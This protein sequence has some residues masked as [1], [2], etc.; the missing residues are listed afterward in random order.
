MYPELVRGRALSV[1]A[2]VA[3]NASV[4]ASCAPHPAAAPRAS[5]PCGDEQVRIEHFCIDR[6]EDYV[7]EVDDQGREKPH[8]PYD[9]IGNK[10][11]RARVAKGVVPQAYISQVQAR[12]AC[13]EAGKRLCKPDEYIRA[14]RGPSKKDLY[15]Y[16]GMQRHTGSCN[17]GKGSFVALAFGQD[18]S[19][20]T[21]EEFNDPRCTIWSAT[22]TSG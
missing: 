5:G 6:Y 4:T 17:E 15:P 22:C 1:L 11:V 3:G 16:G 8:S 13:A 9:V 7:V 10:R 2:I 14:C 21:Y 12:A 18:F 19:K 20:R